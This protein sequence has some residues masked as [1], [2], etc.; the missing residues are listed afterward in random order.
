MST[1]QKN[2]AYKGNISLSSDAMPSN[3]R[4]K[5][6][7]EV[8]NNMQSLPI[9]A[10]QNKGGMVRDAQ[11]EL[12][13]LSSGL[14][15]TEKK[16]DKIGRSLD[17]VGYDSEEMRRRMENGVL[18]AKSKLVAYCRIN[19]DEPY[20]EFRDGLRSY[21]DKSQFKDDSDTMA[22]P[23]EE[24]R[25]ARIKLFGD[26]DKLSE[27]ERRMRGKAARSTSPS[28]T[29]MASWKAGQMLGARNV[30]EQSESIAKVKE[31]ISEDIEGIGK[32][33]DAL[34]AAIEKLSEAYAVTKMSADSRTRLGK[35]SLNDPKGAVIGAISN[36][37]VNDYMPRFDYAIRD[38]S[39]RISG[40]GQDAAGYEIGG[41]A[42]H[43]GN[44]AP[45]GIEVVDTGLGYDGPSATGMKADGQ[46][47]AASTSSGQVSSRWIKEAEK[48]YSDAFISWARLSKA[49][50]DEYENMFTEL[51]RTRSADLAS[52]IWKKVNTKWLDLT[53][54][55]D[56]DDKDYF[57]RKID[58]GATMDGM[59]CASREMLSL[60]ISHYRRELMV[61][62][63]GADGEK[64]DG[65]MTNG[66]K[67]MY[68]A[69]KVTDEEERKR[70]QALAERNMAAVGD[71]LKKA[72]VDLAA[73]HGNYR[74]M[75]ILNDSN[76]FQGEDIL[77]DH[78]YRL[79]Y[80]AYKRRKLGDVDSNINMPPP[81]P[82][83]GSGDHAENA[84]DGTGPGTGTVN[85]PPMQAR[86]DGETYD[87]GNESK[88][89]DLG[90]AGP[91]GSQETRSIDTPPPPPGPS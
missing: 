62:I 8:E 91:A 48:Y 4:D 75:K 58:S 18:S 61:L 53:D 45:E 76:V 56:V 85:L 84:Q 17:D 19:G 64:L 74:Q 13:K 66:D 25:K 20:D 23:V 88:I 3:W 22:V 49:E 79:A 63:G 60:H 28:Y 9:A 78:M 33:K 47:D 67:M 65:L 44:G 80:N 55:I 32:L 81:M 89:V 42:S 87:S 39:A 29:D 41:N 27:E 72:H 35:D 14:M 59:K 70:L 7:K 54:T 1:A 10:A 50:T 83:F 21:A 52:R 43:K 5:V 73:F 15:L 31:T 34:Y 69:A 57:Q 90:N 30:Q 71:L 16:L 24:F 11:G 68:D 36:A 46:T 51:K 26:I 86:I 38:G 37:D 2:N 82:Y 40:A 12:R 77:W 6:R